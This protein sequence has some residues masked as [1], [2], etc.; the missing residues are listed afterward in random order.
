MKANNKIKKVLGN[1]YFLMYFKK[2]NNN[3]FTIRKIYD[4]E[5][6]HEPTLMKQIATISIRNASLI[7]LDDFRAFPAQPA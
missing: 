5:H 2:I 4:V 3:I 7:Q 1:Y 6:Y